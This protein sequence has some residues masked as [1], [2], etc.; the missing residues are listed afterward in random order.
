MTTILL[1]ADPT[2]VTRGVHVAGGRRIVETALDKYGRL[3]GMVCCAGIMSTKYLWELEEHE[4]DDVVAVRSPAT[5]RP[6]A[7]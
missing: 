4:W 2:A 1:V 7:S 6:R 3:H 5:R